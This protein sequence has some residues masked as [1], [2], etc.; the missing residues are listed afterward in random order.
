VPRHR[1]PGSETN[2][3]HQGKLF[4][5]QE[6]YFPNLEIVFPRRGNHFLVQGTGVLGQENHFPA[7]E[8]YFSIPGKPFPN[9]EKRCNY[10]V[11]EDLCE[12]AGCQARFA[13]FNA[14]LIIY[15]RR[16]RK[17]DKLF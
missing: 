12:K 7:L 9:Q 1:F 13:H 15:G 8:T 11:N 5:G 14:H 2:S 3:P 4:P 16:S 10:P 6:F 17:P